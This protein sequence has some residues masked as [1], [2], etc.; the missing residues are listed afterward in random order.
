MTIEELR[1]DIDRIDSEMIRLYAKR[2]ETAKQIGQYKKEHHLPVY[3]PSREREVLNRAAEAA[4]EENGNGV[5]ALF[6]FLMAQSRASQMLEGKEQ[7]EMGRLISQ[8]L[9]ETCFPLLR[10]DCAITA[11][12]RSKTAWRVP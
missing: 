9:E 12:C 6:S 1:A 5:R 4:G 11:S 7:S 10:T 3:D 2:L 8:S